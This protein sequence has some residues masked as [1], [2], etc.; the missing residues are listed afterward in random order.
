MMRLQRITYFDEGLSRL[1]KFSLDE[2]LRN[3]LL[4][5]QESCNHLY[6]LRYR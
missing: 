5:R 6:P 4:L 2:Y 3:L 1:P